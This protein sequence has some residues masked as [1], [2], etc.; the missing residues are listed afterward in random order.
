MEYADFGAGAITY[1]GQFVNGFRHGEG[2]ALFHNSNSEYE[3]EWVCDEPI[4]L[5]IFQH[6]GPLIQEEESDDEGD[7][8][9]VFSVPMADHATSD[10][11]SKFA[12]SGSQS[13]AS[14][15]GT[16]SSG[17]ATGRLMIERGEDDDIVQGSIAPTADPDMSDRPSKLV[18]STNDSLSGS[19]LTFISIEDTADWT[20]MSSA[21]RS[22]SPRPVQLRR[23]RRSFKSVDFDG[24][25]DLS[26]KS[27]TVMDFGDRP[28][29]IYHYANGDVFKGH[30]DSNNLRQGSGVYTEHRMGSTYEGEMVAL[31]VCLKYEAAQV[32]LTIIFSYSL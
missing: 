18:S 19:L 29:E 11:A 10:R 23:R 14:G 21:K 1:T 24:G 22:K 16:E 2:R 27:L 28:P 15:I 5:K 31:F 30:L 9:Q 8:I 3:G 4:G 17:L 7:V 13:Q 26:M 32:Q 6:N 25:L 12:E 20:T